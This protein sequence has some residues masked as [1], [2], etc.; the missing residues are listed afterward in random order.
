VT[1]TYEER[2]NRFLTNLRNT[3]AAQC[4]G[5][6]GDGANK[7]A[8][9]AGCAGETTNIYNYLPSFLTDTVW[10]LNDAGLSFEEILA[11]FESGVLSLTMDERDH[12]YVLGRYTDR[13]NDFVGIGYLT[14]YDEGFRKGRAEREAG[15]GTESYDLD[16]EYVVVGV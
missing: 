3:R 13:S 14:Y 10:M 7:C 8:L 16:S 2:L 12:G 9:A 1:Q 11:L 6:A 5:Y 4:F 15:K